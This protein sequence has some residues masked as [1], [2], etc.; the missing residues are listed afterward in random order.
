[1]HS[2]DLA[3]DQ[4]GWTAKSVQH[5]LSCLRQ[6]NAE[7]MEKK[8][9]RREFSAKCIFAT[10]LRKNPTPA[11]KALREAFDKAGMKYNFQIVNRGYIP[12]FYFGGA[13]TII[14]VDGPIHDRQREYDAHRDQVFASAGIT[15]IRV[16]NEEVLADADA[17]VAKLKPFI[18]ERRRT[19]RAVHKRLKKLSKR[20][21][22]A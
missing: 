1:M 4:I 2:I 21:K 17:V 6:S 16:K 20:R 13:K 12:D 11:E 15:T 5:L 9:K 14:E 18:V 22:A 7:E 10:S 19:L 3:E 8:L